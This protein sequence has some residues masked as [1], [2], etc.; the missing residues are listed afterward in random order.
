MTKSAKINQYIVENFKLMSKDEMAEHFGITTRTIYNRIKTLRDKKLLPKSKNYKRDSV[1][2]KKDKNTFS[3]S[4]GVYKQQARTKMVN[5]ITLQGLTLSLPFE[6]CELEKQILDK[7]ESGFK[8]V[9]C[10]MEI[11]TYKRMLDTISKD[12]A[13]LEAVQP[14]FGKTTDKLENAKENEYSNLLLDYCGVL[15]TFADEIEHAVENNT[16]KAGGAIC[17]T[18][19][20]RGYQGDSIKNRTLAQFPKGMYGNSIGDVE[21]TTKLFFNILVAKNE[22]YSIEEFFNY[23]DDKKDDNG[24]AVLNSRGV[25]VKNAPMML[26]ILRRNK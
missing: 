2:R 14:Y 9:G 24:Q 7:N 23:Q 12:D 25:Q 18:L 15:D 26:V 4:N 20:K 19:N 16:V 17:V 8:F 10:E 11:D 3:N 21:L 22:N 13:L 5:A 1:R 6:T